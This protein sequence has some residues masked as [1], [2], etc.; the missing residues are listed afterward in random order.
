MFVS[1]IV[2]SIFIF[3]RERICVRFSNTMVEPAE[4]EAT[5]GLERR[6]IILVALLALLCYNCSQRQQ[7]ISTRERSMNPLCMSKP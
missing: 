7:M 6:A 1:N 5:N 4:A 3:A 2:R